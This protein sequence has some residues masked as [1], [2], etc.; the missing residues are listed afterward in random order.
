MFDKAVNSW[1]DGYR[2]IFDYQGRA[3]RREFGSFLVIQFVLFFVVAI[4]SS[5]LF[6]GS[7]FMST[8]IAT[9]VVV[10]SLAT[11]LPYNVRRLH[12]AGQSG[13]ACLAY[14]GFAPVIIGVSLAMVT[15][16]KNNKYVVDTQA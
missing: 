4:I 2:K 13:W 1:L 8:I 9:V 16:E 12:D 6:G 11:M 15:K 14:I 10:A 5:R 7:S 3:T